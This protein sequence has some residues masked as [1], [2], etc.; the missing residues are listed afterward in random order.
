MHKTIKNKIAALR[1]K[2]RV[3]IAVLDSG[4]GGL[5]ICAE[6]EAVLQV[7]P[8]FKQVSLIYF[9]VWPEPGR[10]YNSFDSVSAR[11]GVFERALKGVKAYGPDL[12]MIACNTLSVI[13]NR[14]PFSRHADI[15][16]VDIVDFGVDLI[17]AGLMENPESPVLILGTR[18][19]ISAN[20]HQKKLV[21]MGVDAHRIAVQACHGVATEIEKDPLGETVQTLIAAYMHEAAQ[22]L[23][24][25]TTL[26]VA[27]CCTH[28]AY[29]MGVFRDTLRNLLSVDIVM[30]NP[31][32]AMSR[33]LFETGCPNA[34]S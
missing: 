26:L 13:Y 34:V 12:I 18:T 3:L 9:N 20:V 2:E 6:L 8:L 21:H 14:T 27:L 33:F 30:L 11:V 10:G 19:T 22:K 28:F 31:N 23:N 17:H 7:K 32:T 15:P 4:L 25:R 16:V 24:S 1:K 29:S 5:S